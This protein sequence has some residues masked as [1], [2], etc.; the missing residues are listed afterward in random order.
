MY[1]ATS[2]PV[3]AT[4]FRTITLKPNVADKDNIVI[5]NVLYLSSI[6][7]SL[8]SVYKLDKRSVFINFGKMKVIIRE[9]NESLIAMG[10]LIWK[11]YGLELNI[12]E[13]YKTSTLMLI[14]RAKNNNKKLWHVR[15]RHLNFWVLST[16]L[17]T[18]PSQTPFSEMTKTAC[19]HFMHQ[20][21]NKTKAY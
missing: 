21:K 17:K 3:L 1:T 14:V 6:N 12:D 11:L 2:E 5:Q 19:L 18:R 7:S 10:K 4:E 16:T 9:C 8:L 20:Q 13:V 15:L